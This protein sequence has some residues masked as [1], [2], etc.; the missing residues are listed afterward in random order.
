MLQFPGR[1]VGRNVVSGSPSLLCF[2]IALLPRRITSEDHTNRYTLRRHAASDMKIYLIYI[3]LIP[4]PQCFITKPVIFLLKPHTTSK[5]P[6]LFFL[7]LDAVNVVEKGE[8]EQ[9]M[10]GSC[11]VQVTLWFNHV[12]R[13]PDRRN[14]NNRKQ[15]NNK[16]QSARPSTRSTGFHFEF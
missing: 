10:V 16:N 5:S 13:V 14:V 8:N 9:L 15:Q 4:E 7:Y 1:S 12:T 2:F 11:S 3:L 6:I